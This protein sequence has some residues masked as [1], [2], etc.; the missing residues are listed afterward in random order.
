MDSYE[1]FIGYCAADLSSFLDAFTVMIKLE[2]THKQTKN[3]LNPQARL[4]EAVAAAGGEEYRKL[5]KF[6]FPI[7]KE[8]VLN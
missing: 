8:Q 1:D 4:D 2:I 7:R 5:Y 6:I 3:I